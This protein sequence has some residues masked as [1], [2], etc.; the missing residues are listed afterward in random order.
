MT[1]RR[2]GTRHFSRHFRQRRAPRPKGRDHRRTLHC[3]WAVHEIQ[4]PSKLTTWNEGIRRQV[5]IV[6]IWKGAMHSY[7]YIRSIWPSFHSNVC[8]IDLVNRCPSDR[9]NSGILVSFNFVKFLPSVVHISFLRLHKTV[10]L[11]IKQI[12]VVFL[13]WALLSALCQPCSLHKPWQPQNTYQEDD[14]RCRCRKLIT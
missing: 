10:S 1:Y 4:L 6:S 9:N 13:D 8:S 3:S 11:Y 7:W 5:S 14:R 12:P 2:L